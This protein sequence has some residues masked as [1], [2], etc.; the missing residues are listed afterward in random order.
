MDPPERKSSLA[1]RRERENL[2]WVGSSVLPSKRKQIEGE[3]RARVLMDAS[4]PL[5]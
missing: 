3:Y 5:A 4:L 2:G 1:E